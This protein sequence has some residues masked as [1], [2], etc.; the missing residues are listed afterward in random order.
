V[1]GSWEVAERDGEAPKGDEDAS[2][3]PPVPAETPT[4]SR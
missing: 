4:G 3:D 1:P 2:A